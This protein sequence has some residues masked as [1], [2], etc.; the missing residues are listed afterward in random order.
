MLIAPTSPEPR[1]ES[2][3]PSQPDMNNTTL[4]LR[5]EGELLAPTAVAR[6][7]SLSRSTIYRLMERGLLP[8]H[9]IC[10]H[11]RV[12]RTDVETLITRSRETI[13]FTRYGSKKD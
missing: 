4:A 1:S 12:R 3:A 2:A 8:V 5:L 6:L 11:L 9:K 10:R 13:G 7:L